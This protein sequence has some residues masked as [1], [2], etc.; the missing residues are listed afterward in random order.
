METITLTFY[1]PYNLVG[2]GLLV[3]GALLFKTLAEFVRG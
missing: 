3:I 1:F 2:S